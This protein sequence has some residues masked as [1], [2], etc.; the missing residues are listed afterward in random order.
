MGP[1]QGQSGCSMA[2]FPK[3]VGALK[4][5]DDLKRTRHTGRA[6]RFRCVGKDVEISIGPHRPVEL[7]GH[8]RRARFAEPFAKFRL[9]GELRDGARQL[10]GVARR[11]RQPGLC[12]FENLSRLAFH[13]Q[14]DGLSRR[15]R[16]E[17]LRREDGLEGLGW[18]QRDER[19]VACGQ[20]I[21]D[22]ASRQQS[23]ELDVRLARFGGTRLQI[24]ELGA[25]A[26]D[27]K[28]QAGQRR[29][30]Q[31][32]RMQYRAQTVRHADSSRVSDGDLIGS[33]AQPEASGLAPP[34][35]P[36]RG[37]DA[38][39]HIAQLLRVDA[40]ALEVRNEAARDTDHGAGASVE[41]KLEPFEQAERQRLSKR[42]DRVNRL[43]PQVTQ[44]EHPWS[45][46]QCGG[47]ASGQR[48]EELR[49][50][51]DDHVEASEPPRT[52]D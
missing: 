24:R 11:D 45:A 2:A 37:R 49:R 12:L 47:A 20:D 36:E 42:A 19:D 41:G 46:T 38:I 21:C 1:S 15:H 29:L 6:Q 34:G 51:R 8:E 22:V 48:A 18:L 17:H 28:A 32:G 13:C 16:L 43:G 7:G 50:R 26:D 40:S 23:C 27:E 4:L 52:E 25:I 44:L 10:D 3:H 9:L 31:P 30:E 14:H 35:G 33:E 5:P 39:G